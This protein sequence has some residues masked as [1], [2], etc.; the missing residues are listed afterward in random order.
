MVEYTYE[1]YESPYGGYGYR[2]LIRGRIIINQPFVPCVGG[3]RGFDTREQAEAVASFI[4]NKANRGE[5][6]GVSL[7]DL[8]NLNAI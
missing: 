7:E 2:I 6:F 4:V 1:V 3:M 8:L 5:G